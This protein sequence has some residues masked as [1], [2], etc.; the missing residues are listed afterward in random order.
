MIIRGVKNLDVLLLCCF[1]IEI[2][3]D[4]AT[5]PSLSNAF[6]THFTKNG[7]DDGIL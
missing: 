1:T 2:R 4:Q 6:S 5:K 7:A 3:K